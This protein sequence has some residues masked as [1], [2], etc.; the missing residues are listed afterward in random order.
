MPVSGQHVDLTRKEN[1]EGVS[2]VVGTREPLAIE[3]S[4]APRGTE[5][6]CVGLRP[7]GGQP[8]AAYLRHRPEKMGRFR[9][10]TFAR[11]S[12]EQQISSPVA[13]TLE[14]GQ[15]QRPVQRSDLSFS[16]SDGP[17]T[18]FFW[19]ELLV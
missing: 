18:D 4:S 2:E 3:K 8:G 13:D 10:W 17:L 16:D 15:A 12:P 19:L 7:V 9:Q 1:L 11:R 14:G 5:T 6:E